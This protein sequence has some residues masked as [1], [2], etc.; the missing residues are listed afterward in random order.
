MKLSPLWRLLSYSPHLKPIALLAGVAVLGE[1]LLNPVLAH[2]MR[3]LVD[4]FLGHQAALYAPLAIRV[5]VLMVAMSL[6]AWARTKTMGHMAEHS[7]AQLRK[8]AAEKLLAIPVPKLDAI[9]TGDHLSR[10]TNDI[11]VIT[12]YLN[13]YAFW[14]LTLPIMAVA[15]LAYMTYIN[16][17]MIVATIA[18]L[19][20]LFFLTSRASAPIGR[21]SKELQQHL[22]GVNNVTQDALGGAE[23]VKA[24]NL[25]TEMEQRFD[26]EMNRTVGSGLKLAGRKALLRA[27]SVL[28]GL[29]PFILPLAIGGYFTI[30]GVITIGD[31][32]AY[33]L[34]LNSVT[35]P[36]SALPNIIGEH[37]RAMGAL[38]RVEEMINE[39]PERSD[40]QAFSPSPNGDVVI[41]AQD[42]FFGYDE[43]HVVSDL[44]FEVTRGETVA[45]VGAS[46]SG[47]TTVFKLLTGFYPPGSGQV[48][49]YG[50]PLEQWQLSAARREMALVAQDT[51][52]FPGTVAENIA[53]GRPE[54]TRE[55]IVDAARQANAHEF[56]TGLTDGYDHVLSERGANLSG[57]QRQRL[58]IARAILVNTPILLLDEAT[59]ALDTE[60]EHLVQQ[61]LDAMAAT[62]TTLVIAHRLSTIRNADRILVLDD[63]RICE[64][65]THQQLMESSGLYRQLYFRQFSDN[66]QQ[67]GNAS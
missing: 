47:K 34:L 6:V 18:F 3:Q 2:Y 60:S 59:S 11:S 9:H 13:T 51:F 46:G 17:Q 20:F 15:A 12:T 44:N 42:V 40:G 65:G 24:Y 55:E 67:G 58:A 36:L 25:Q 45:L 33:I 57:G 35:F 22:A 52:L 61:A 7:A 19:P 56:I 8:R 32:L 63:G 41:A 5:V 4:T 50:K 49:L 1:A 64:S 53:L 38:E 16:W 48:L 54:A 29:F 43:E 27:S 66:G 31:L 23:V 28:S 39:P 10:L 14:L 26:T 62:R 21:I 30:Q 37:Q